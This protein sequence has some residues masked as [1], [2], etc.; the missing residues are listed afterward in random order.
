MR[1]RNRCAAGE[2]SSVASYTLSLISQKEEKEKKNCNDRCTR[3][4]FLSAEYSSR[5]PGPPGNIIRTA[6]RADL[7]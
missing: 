7:H 2:S 3:R 4:D 6:S 5:I 1:A